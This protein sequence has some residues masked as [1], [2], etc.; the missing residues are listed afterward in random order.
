M[1]VLSDDAPNQHQECYIS[2]WQE[3]AF[4]NDCALSWANHVGI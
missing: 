4:L 3:A 2:M 1:A